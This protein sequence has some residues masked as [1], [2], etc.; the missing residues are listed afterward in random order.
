MYKVCMY[1]NDKMTK[2]PSRRWF[3]T[4]LKMKHLLE[5][6]NFDKEFLITVY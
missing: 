6:I 4:F 5:G 2:F 3:D 1:Q